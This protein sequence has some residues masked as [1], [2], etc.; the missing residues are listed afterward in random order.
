MEA[1]MQKP[2]EERVVNT[3]ICLPSSTLFAPMEL[4]TRL[5][6]PSY[7]PSGIMNMV[8]MTFCKITLAAK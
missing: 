4:P 6:M 8:V 2:I 3:A 7:K 1:K 5:Q